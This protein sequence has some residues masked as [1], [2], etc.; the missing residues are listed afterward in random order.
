MKPLASE[1]TLRCDF[2]NT[3]T[4]ENA[5]NAIS[6]IGVMP[7]LTA[8][9]ESLARIQLGLNQDSFPEISA[10]IF[11]SHLKWINTPSDLFMSVNHYSQPHLGRRALQNNIP[12]LLKKLGGFQRASRDLYWVRSDYV[13]DLG[14]MQIAFL[15]A[16]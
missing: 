14:S 4:A 1:S 10:T 12:E 2:C 15:P 8:H 16:F 9:Y 5:S 6:P 3:H 7:D 11:G 13:A